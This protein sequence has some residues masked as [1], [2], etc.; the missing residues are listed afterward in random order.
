[1]KINKPY[2]LNI[3]GETPGID[4]F[5]IKGCKLTT[6]KQ[7][8]MCLLANINQMQLLG[9]SGVNIKSEA[10]KKVVDREVVA[11][12][13]KAGVTI[14][15]PNLIKYGISKLN[16]DYGNMRK[17]AKEPPDFVA[18]TMPFWSKNS[19]ESLTKK[20]RSKFLGDIEKIG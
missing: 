5:K 13:G 10:I 20:L 17:S 9:S 11:V 18:K 16:N 6:Y 12:Y 1:M 3:L 7:V 15:S 19:K 4:H 14:I 2:T 8:L